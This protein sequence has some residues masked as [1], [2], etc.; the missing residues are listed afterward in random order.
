M[1]RAKSRLIADAI[2]AQDN[3]ASMA[4]WYGA[5]LMTGATVE[6]VKLWPSRIRAVTAEQVQDAA[7]QWLDKKRSVTGYLI[8]DTAPQSEQGRNVDSR[9]AAKWRSGHDAL[10]ALRFAPRLAFVAAAPAGLGDEDRKDRQPVRHHGLAGARAG[11]A[12]GDAELRLSWRLQPGP[13][14]KSGTANLAADTLDEGAG[15]LDGK[16]YHERL[17]NHAIELSFRVGRDEF[18]GSL[19]SLNEHRDE[20]FDLLRLALTAPRFEAEAVER[21]R[22]QELSG[23]RRETTNPNN[24]SSRRWWQTAFPGSPL[25][26]RDQRHAGDGAEH[27]RRRSARLCPPRVRAQ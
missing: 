6:D 3:Q 11:G 2:Y 22:R 14:D 19:R 13:A 5:A 10:S 18:R 27:H 17:E 7:R 25:R 16:T 8:K 4:R 1:D 26:P 21:V 9:Q 15:D 23:L 24:I 12:A 20:A